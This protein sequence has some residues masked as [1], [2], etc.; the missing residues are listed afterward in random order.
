MC[1]ASSNI[2]IFFEIKMYFCFKIRNLIIKMHYF[3]NKNTLLKKTISM[4][5]IVCKKL[6][7]DFETSLQD[8]FLLLK[9]HRLFVEPNLH[10]Y[11]PTISAFI[12]FKKVNRENVNFLFSKNL[13]FESR[14]FHIMLYCKFI[15]I[16]YIF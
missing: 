9:A 11:L 3:C 15:Y 7:S 12:F 10:E 5:Q 14:H 8:F 4:R 16:L 6:Q 2:N 13:Y 1:I